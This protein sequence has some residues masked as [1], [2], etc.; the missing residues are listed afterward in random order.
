V[1]AA[2]RWAIEPPI[3]PAPM[4]QTFIAQTR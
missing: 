4:M 2:K 1:C 3:A